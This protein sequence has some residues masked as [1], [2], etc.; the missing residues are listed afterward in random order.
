MTN[1]MRANAGNGSTLALGIAQGEVG[2][3][4]VNWTWLTFPLILDVLAIIL[5]GTIIWQ[6]E[7][8]KVES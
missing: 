4:S 6:S 7:S 3:T 5:L 2:Y 8:M 1:D